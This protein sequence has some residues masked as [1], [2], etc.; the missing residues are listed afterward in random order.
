MAERQKLVYIS[1]E[2]K[3][4]E[5]LGKQRPFSYTQILLQNT[6][7]VMG[8]KPRHAFKIS[9]HVFEILRKN[10][11]LSLKLSKNLSDLEAKCDAGRCVHKLKQ[12]GEEREPHLYRK[13]STYQNKQATI[14]IHRE[15]F[16]DVVCDALTAYRYVGPTQRAD[17]TLACRIQE[18]KVSLTIL[19]CGTSGCGKSTLSTL[20]GAS[21]SGK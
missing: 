8:C 9:K 13:L 2:D 3:Q 6:L 16:L 11:L 20:L 19:L 7:Q 17:L 10:I 21:C 14:T 15:Q 1:V 12:I 18:R 4:S 5:K